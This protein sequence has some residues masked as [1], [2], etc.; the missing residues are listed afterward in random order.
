[1]KL[2]MPFIP[3]LANEC[4]EQLN[5]QDLDKWP[6]LET[7]ILRDTKVNIVIQINGKVCNLAKVSQGSVKSVT[8]S[9]GETLQGVESVL[10]DVQQ[11]IL[12]L[13][14]IVKLKNALNDIDGNVAAVPV[15]WSNSSL[16]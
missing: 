16:Y 14:Y 6:K 3:H 15:L 13:E 8:R 12:N 1:M 7:N 9:K 2:T 10:L 5:A 11:N 4:L